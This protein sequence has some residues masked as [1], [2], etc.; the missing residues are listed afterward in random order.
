M[1]LILV[2]CTLITDLNM[3]CLIRNISDSSKKFYKK[4]CCRDTGSRISRHKKGSRSS[5]AFYF[6]NC[7]SEDSADPKAFL[8]SQNYCYDQID[9]HCFIFF[10]YSLWSIVHRKGITDN[11]SLWDKLIQDSLT[12]LNNWYWDVNLDLSVFI[13]CCY[14]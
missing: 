13:F 1:L 11:L 8:L 4:D 10:I 2:G 3:N 14:Y 7:V 12:K 6:W 9:D 5:L